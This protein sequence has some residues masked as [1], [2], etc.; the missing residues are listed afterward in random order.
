MEKKNKRTWDNLTPEQKDKIREILINAWN[1]IVDNILTPE[2]K[3]AE[4]MV[5]PAILLQVEE[6]IN[7]FANQLGL[8]ALLEIDEEN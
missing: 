8:S 7:M 6:Q 3:D 2:N 5:D 4:G 1:N